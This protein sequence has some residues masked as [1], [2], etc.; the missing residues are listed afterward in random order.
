[1]N[2]WIHEAMFYHIY[3]LGYCGAPEYNDGQQAYRLEKLREW[4]PHL[5]ALHVTA[6]Y[7]G[8]GGDPSPGQGRP[9]PRPRQRRAPAG[10]GRMTVPDPSVTRRSAPMSC[11]SQN[12]ICIFGQ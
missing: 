11:H 8:P 12:N 4:I 5:R 3:P 9:D 7:L 6:L 1:M 10:A 2:S